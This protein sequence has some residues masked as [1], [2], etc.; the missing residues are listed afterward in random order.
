MI[1]AVLFDL[2]QTLIDFLGMKKEASRKAA[3][4]MIKAGLRLDK[5]KAGRQLFE[6]YLKHGIDSDTAFERFIKK[7]HGKMDYKIL[8]A[9][10][11]AYLSSKLIDPNSSYSLSTMDRSTVTSAGTRKNI[12]VRIS[13]TIPIMTMDSGN[14]IINQEPKAIGSALGKV[15]SKIRANER[16]GG[17]PTRVAAPPSEQA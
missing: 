13:Q 7:M 2:D 3:N 16:F 9:G 5:R 6:F 4:A 8:A 12:L 15:I 11:N 17:V 14:P 10:I 1:K